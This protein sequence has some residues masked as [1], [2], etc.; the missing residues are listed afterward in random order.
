MRICELCQVEKKDPEFRVFGRGRRKVCL[1]C[2]N[3]MAGE[4]ATIAD[5]LPQPIRL[6]ASLEVIPGFGF[7]ASIEEGRLVIEQDDQAGTSNVTLA[8]HEARQLVDWISEQ[9]GEEQ[10]A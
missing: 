4:A 9:I 10:A 3:G 5:E 8:P 2:E 6:G 1:A 7:R